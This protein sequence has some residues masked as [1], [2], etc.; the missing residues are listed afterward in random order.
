MSKNL[1][2]KKQV[3]AEIIEKFKSAESVVICSYN[4][5]TV[6]QVTELRKQCR[7]NG[8]QGQ[9]YTRLS[10]MTE[11]FFMFTEQNLM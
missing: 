1:E 10:V 3:V 2:I 6:E 11:E 5:L 4:G 7:E 8:L 9:N